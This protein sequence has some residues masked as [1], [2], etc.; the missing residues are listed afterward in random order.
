LCLS[1]AAPAPR[2]TSRNR[3]RNSV[4]PVV[5][6]GAGRAA[7]H[8]ALSG[9]VTLLGKF[10]RLVQER[11]AEPVV[12][13]FLAAKSTR[14]IPDMFFASIR[15][16]TSILLP[17]TTATRLCSMWSKL[18]VLLY[19]RFLLR[20]TV[21]H[22]ASWILVSRVMLLQYGCSFFFPFLA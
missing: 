6:A 9:Q 22:L 5:C 3:S 19:Y 11:L 17:V 2:S 15:F 1:A 21:Q 8:S 10:S 18:P 12:F 14:S 7:E 13:I 4:T 20:Q 16:R